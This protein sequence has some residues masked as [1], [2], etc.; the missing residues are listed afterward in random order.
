[1]PSETFYHF[2][3]RP[4]DVVPIFIRKCQTYARINATL[5]FSPQNMVTIVCDNKYQLEDLYLEIITCAQEREDELNPRF[6]R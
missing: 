3:L 6:Y 5:R 1:M 2:P 4:L